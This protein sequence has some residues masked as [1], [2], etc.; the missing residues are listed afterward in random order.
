LT[1]SV[2]KESTGVGNVEIISVICD[3]QKIKGENRDPSNGVEAPGCHT[4]I[5]AL[6]S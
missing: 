1:A 2:A 3:S 5:K 4:E 6:G